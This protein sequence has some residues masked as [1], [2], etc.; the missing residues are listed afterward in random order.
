MSGQGAG[1]AGTSRGVMAEMDWKRAD[2][3][4][5]SAGVGGAVAADFGFS[6][7]N[8]LCVSPNDSRR[9]EFTSCFTGVNFSPT[10][11]LTFLADLFGVLNSRSTLSA[12]PVGVSLRLR[13]LLLFFAELGG[14]STASGFL[15]L[16]V[17]RRN[18]VSDLESAI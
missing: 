11:F 8:K 9:D 6:S 7:S 1:E 3:S 16:R 18:G 14:L 5:V 10:A 13:L 4:S 12:S 17:E 15:L 2:C